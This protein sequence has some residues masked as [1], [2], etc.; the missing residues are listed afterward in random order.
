MVLIGIFF[1]AG[2]RVGDCAALVGLRAGIS[3]SGDNGIAGFRIDFGAATAVY[4][5]KI[6][7]HIKAGLMRVALSSP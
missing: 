3:L 4:K 5:V 7:A 6:S 1:L 2:E